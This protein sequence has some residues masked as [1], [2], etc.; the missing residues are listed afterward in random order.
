MPSAVYLANVC[1]R[2]YHCPQPHLFQRANSF[3]SREICN[4]RSSVVLSTEATSASSMLRNT[5]A[6]A[7]TGTVHMV[8]VS[9]GFDNVTVALVRLRWR[10]GGKIIKR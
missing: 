2:F 3:S 4:T 5:A 7:C 10:E 8:H 6:W 1:H 9:R